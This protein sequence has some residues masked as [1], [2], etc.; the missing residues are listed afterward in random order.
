MIM[1]LYVST[2]ALVSYPNAFRV[3]NVTNY[4]DKTVFELNWHE[5]R[6]KLFKRWQNYLCLA[7][8]YMPVKQ[9]IKPEFMKL[10][11]SYRG[12]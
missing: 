1:F 7:V 3:V 8:R 6:Q 11:N 12:L 5:T 10:R 9:K 4:S 2:P